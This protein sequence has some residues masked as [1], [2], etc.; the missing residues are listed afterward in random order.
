MS[1]DDALASRV[2]E[3]LRRARLVEERRM[4]G[5]LTFM[6]RGKIVSVWVRGASCAGSTLR[7]TML[8]SNAR[9]AER[10]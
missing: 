3:A 9:A 2:K 6:V 1:Y 4:F 10:S 5:G 7:F 8:R